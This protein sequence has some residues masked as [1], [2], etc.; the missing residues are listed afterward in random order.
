MYLDQHLTLTKPSAGAH[1]FVEGTSARA[2]EIWTHIVVVQI[3]SFDPLHPR[4]AELLNRA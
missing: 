3:S 1:L 4:L 2:Q